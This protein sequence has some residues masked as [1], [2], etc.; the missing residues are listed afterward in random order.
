MRFTCLRYRTS[1]ASLARLAQ[2]NGLATVRVGQMSDDEYRKEFG[3]GVD[4]RLGAQLVST[5]EQLAQCDRE[6]ADLIQGTAVRS[7]R[8]GMLPTEGV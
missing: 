8:L 1:A 5:R 2:V 6:L 4:L 3:A 7:T